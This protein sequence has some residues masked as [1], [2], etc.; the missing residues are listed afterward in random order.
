MLGKD[1]KRVAI[2]LSNNTIHQ[3]TKEAKKC[4]YTFSNLINRLL[5]DWLQQ[6]KK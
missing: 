6:R 2:T 1:K 5:D 3:V 4:G